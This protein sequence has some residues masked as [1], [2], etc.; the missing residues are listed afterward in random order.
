MPLVRLTASEEYFL[1]SFDA[2]GS[3]RREADGT[4]LSERVLKLLADPTSGYTDVFLMSHGWK[5]DLP[6]AREQY[7][8]WVKT[9]AD[10]VVGRERIRAR[11]PS[12]KPLM[13]GL[14][15]PSLPFGDENIAA[16]PVTVLGGAGGTL[17]LAAVDA[18]AAGTANT[19]ASRHAIH[20]LLA[21]ARSTNTP[22]LSVEAKAAYAVLVEEVRAGA[23]GDNGVGLDDLPADPQAI[24]DASV[25]GIPPAGARGRVLG[26]SGDLSDL[27]LT[28]VRQLS[29]WAMKDRARRFGETGAR[30]L[31]EA[32]ASR[33]A[34]AGQR[35]HLMGHSFGCIVVS[36]AVAGP[37]PAGG[38]PVDT[39]FLVQG[40]LSLW[41]FADEIPMAPGTPGYL[42]RVLDGD[43][44]V[45]G[46]VVA[47]QSRFDRAVGTFYPI[48]AR[49][50]RQL[51][52]GSGDLPK[53][54]G[55]GTFGIRGVARARDLSI[56]PT[57]SGYAFETKTVY[58]IESSQIIK[59]GGGFAGAHSDI[60]HPEVA[61]VLWE[62]VRCTMPAV[63]M[64]PPLPAASGQPAAIRQY[65]G[66]LLGRAEVS[67]AAPA[68]KNFRGFSRP[69]APA[70]N[71]MLSA[72]G[73]RGA[74][75]DAKAE[76]QPARKRWVNAELDRDPT[77]DP[78]A[79]GYWYT[80]KVDIALDARISSAVVFEGEDA[81]P[82]GERDIIV[83]VQVASSDFDVARD[84]GTLRIGREG[85]SFQPA[86]FGVS[87]LR[88]GACTLQVTLHRD[89]N[90]IQQLTVAV[91]VG[92]PSAMF[93]TTVGRPVSAATAIQPR[94]IGISLSPYGSGYECVVW[95]SVA[96]RATLPVSQAQLA[97]AVDTY[98]RSLLKVVGYEKRFGDL[99]F[100]FGIDIPAEAQDDALEIMAG[101]GARLFQKLFYAPAAGSD[102][103]DLGDFLRRELGQG[104]PLKKLQVLTR[105]VPIPWACLY[106]GDVR[107]RES[108]RWDKFIGFS[109]VVE[110]IP[111]QP[112][113]LV[114]NSDVPSD[115]PKLSV[116]LN[117]NTKI[118]GS[119]QLDVVAAQEAYWAQAEAG[120]RIAVKRRETKREILDAMNDEA[121]DDQVLYFYCHAET[122]ALGDA[123]GPDGSSLELTDDKL[124]LGELALLAPAE[125][126]LKGMPL[127]FINACESAALSPAFYDGFV[128]YFM[129]KGARGVVGTECN[130]P[131]LFA[132]D[133]AQR[134][135]D[136]F[137]NGESVG[138]AF[139]SLRQEYLVAHRNPLGLLY[140]VHCDGDTRISPAP[141]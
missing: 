34:V 79:V 111:L 27:I 51:V 11:L 108:L 43:G 136:R 50:G 69:A 74:T 2:E 23:S 127:V 116:S 91:E 134:F 139:L 118:D 76:T 36:A 1:I 30:A 67:P 17:A 26:S 22:Q 128:P 18:V 70:T 109:H 96:A 94:D 44:L 49:V 48:G 73:Q 92:K 95:G 120:R 14:H 7:D 72:P 112:N 88:N 65:R 90:F 83:T 52:L 113:L 119:M 66:G 68:G 61:L 56:L 10:E 71:S 99:P 102:S 64:E 13:I 123:G 122:A 133:F 60:A 40:A 32:L 78:L 131:A 106:L 54:G 110:Q 117:V 84:A 140:A 15:W 107:T 75:V 63:R 125:R 129:A 103:H 126:P 81:F 86:L 105:E 101:A 98:R 9:M 100:Q 29:F 8:A 19:P 45:R 20:E 114:S 121:L 77:H 21:F 82:E 130:T 35:I 80:L 53:Y 6:A 38:I 12:F 135:F 33:A 87:P 46:V 57:G 62:A 37:G 24:I 39:L 41:A 124:T 31:L 85:P 5:G 97:E 3:E 115:K 55:I 138:T 47:T 141:A 25:A 16:T 132:K 42:R 4:M 58:N 137:L 104:G 93:V 28:P 59:S 89:G